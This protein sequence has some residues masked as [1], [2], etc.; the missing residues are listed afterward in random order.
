VEADVIVI[1]AGGAGMIA[2]MTAADSGARVLHLEKLQRIGGVWAYLGG[3][4]TGAGTRA[5]ARAGILN[6][7]PSRYYSDLLN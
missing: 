6:D 5:Q 2:A 3:T 7:S 1:G 4:I